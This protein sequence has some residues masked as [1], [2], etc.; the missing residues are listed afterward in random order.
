MKVMDPGG[1]GEGSPPDAL[2]S[3]KSD[4]GDDGESLKSRNSNDEW[5]SS[6]RKEGIETVGDDVK[7]NGGGVRSSST[8][9]AEGSPSHGIQMQSSSERDAGNLPDG[10]QSSLSSAGADSGADANR[11]AAA[12]ATT[13]LTS[14]PRGVTLPPPPQVKVTPPPSDPDSLEQL[15]VPKSKAGG[16]LYD[17]LVQEI[18]AAKAQQRLMLKAIDGM[19]RN[20]TALSTTL[21]RVRTEYEL[22][23]AE[24]RAKVDA[25]VETKVRTVERDFAEMQRIMQSTTK[26]E[27]AAL[28]LLAMLAG[29]L[30]LNMQGLGSLRWKIMRRIVATLVVANGTVGV[31]LHMQG[32]IQGTTTMVRLIAKNFSGLLRQ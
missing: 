24:L 29:A 2:S 23:D 26:R 12:R 20:L 11:S 16:S 32:G 17:L 31:L 8:R 5:S 9:G 27:H 22:S 7:D 10:A 28:S 6:D 1:G 18:R 14:G 25:Q 21:Y 30:V 3:G 19:Q 13:K 15:P 4:R